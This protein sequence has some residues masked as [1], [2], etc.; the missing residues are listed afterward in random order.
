MITL[1]L[2][3]STNQGSIAV[4][5]GTAT[6][7][8]KSWQREKSHSELV[9]ST[10]EDVL[11][12]AG[13]TVEKV[14]RIAVGRGPGSFTGIR[15]GINAARTL[16]YSL[17]VP[18]FAFD[19]NTILAGAVPVK[20]EPLLT[21]VNAHKNLL[22]SALFVPENGIWKRIEGPS[23]WTLEQ[24]EAKVQTPTIC[25]GD[26]YLEFIDLFEPSLKSRLI[27]N[28]HVPDYP[29]AEVLG[30]LS[31]E[32]SAQPLVWKE[33]QALYIRAS[34]AEEKLRENPR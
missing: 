4:L 13:L 3:T 8:H 27:R 34:E 24:I 10:L 11:K 26:G 30:R 32:K 29:S 23:A 25:V 9:T 20:Q 22:Y 18:V 33:L 1:A 21:V 17:D 28:H 12:E 19:T 2:D 14:Q 16:A 31:L 6:L 5:D 7:S 15:I